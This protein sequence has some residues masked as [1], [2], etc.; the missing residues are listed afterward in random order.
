MQTSSAH[1]RRPIYLAL[2]L[3]AC[4]ADHA[5][6]RCG[7]APRG[8][9]AHEEHAWKHQ[10]KNEQGAA[11][12][13]LWHTNAW[14]TTVVGDWSPPSLICGVPSMQQTF[15]CVHPMAP[16]CPCHRQPQ[17]RNATES[18]SWRGLVEGRRGLRQ[19]G[20]RG[21]HRHDPAAQHGGE[22]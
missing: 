11:L 13:L 15:A 4:V 1:D 5:A 2:L 3:A 10:V 21:R 17:A 12:L 6:V 18:W 16:C 22:N 19:A 9:S 20:Q 7:G 14:Q 8:L